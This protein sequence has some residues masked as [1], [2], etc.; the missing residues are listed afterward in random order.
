MTTNNEEKGIVYSNHNPEFDVDEDVL[1]EGVAA[2][3]AIAFE[4]LK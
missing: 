2:Y 3:L 4:Y 1:W